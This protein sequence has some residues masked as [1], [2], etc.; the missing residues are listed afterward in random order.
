M[1]FKYDDFPMGI[2]EEIIFNADVNELA[3][4]IE[5]Y[6][7][8]LYNAVER[9]VEK[10]EDFN[11]ALERLKS[12]SNLLMSTL[13][14]WNNKEIGDKEK[15]LQT[16]IYLG[17]VLEGVLQLFLFAFESDYID[18][19][20]KEWYNEDGEKADFD[21]IKDKIYLKLNELVNEKIITAKQK[22]DIKEA[23][24]NELKYRNGKEISKIM[25]N[26][27]ISLFEHEKILYDY[28]ND[29]NGS[30]V[31]DD[32]NG[33]I[34]IDKMNRIREG[35]NSIHIF[36]H[37][38]ELAKDEM[39]ELVRDL[40]FVMRDMLFRVRCLDEQEKSKAYIESIVENCG[41]KLIYEDS[42]GLIIVS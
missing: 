16:S 31:R 15:V 4:I 37:C 8:E 22:R 26:E 18:A 33:K 28:I 32:I 34:I 38:K 29:E 36:T 23:I 39:I 20:W 9:T 7:F 6:S 13:K 11:K 3:R 25:L 5:I 24:N 17:S 19:H 2:N 30:V 10:K 42:E 21:H 14:M 41:A 1:L 35:R 12:F 40:C 27:L